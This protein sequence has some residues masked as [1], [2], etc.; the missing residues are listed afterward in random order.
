MFEYAI[1]LID[2]SEKKKKNSTLNVLKIT[3]K[4]I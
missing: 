2:L 3:N 1:N 4:Y